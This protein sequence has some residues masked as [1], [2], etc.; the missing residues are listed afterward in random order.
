MASAAQDSMHAN[1]STH[2]QCAVFTLE[3]PTNGPHTSAEHLF[4]PLT[5][6]PSKHALLTN[7]PGLTQDCGGIGTFFSTL[8]FCTFWLLVLSILCV[9]IKNKYPVP[10]DKA[11]SLLLSNFERSFWPTREPG[12]RWLQYV[13]FWMIFLRLSEVVCRHSLCP[14]SD[15]TT[16]LIQF[17]S[18]LLGLIVWGVS[19]NMFNK[20]SSTFGKC[21]HSI[22]LTDINWDNNRTY[23]K[24]CD[25]MLFLAYVFCAINVF[26]VVPPD[27]SVAVQSAY[28]GPIVFLPWLSHQVLQ[29]IWAERLPQIGDPFFSFMCIALFIIAVMWILD[30]KHGPRK[31]MEAIVGALVIWLAHCFFT[32][33]IPLA[34]ARVAVAAAMERN[35]SMD[36]VNHAIKN[37]HKYDLDSFQRLLHESK[38]DRNNTL[39]CR[40]VITVGALLCTD[41]GL[42]VLKDVILMRQVSWGHH[43]WLIFAAMYICRRLYFPTLD[44]DYQRKVAVLEA[45]A[46]VAPHHKVWTDA[47]IDK[48][49]K[50]LEPET[51]PSKKIL[52]GLFV[53]VLLPAVPRYILPTYKSLLS[54]M[55]NNTK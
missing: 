25:E 10:S 18:Q 3:C 17:G 36:R 33:L 24:T 7:P 16:A 21:P 31:A 55:Y 8:H 50:L 13:I 26:L 37:I 28:H 48:L 49:E 46:F 2:G 15:T 11:K 6:V 5:R 30:N 51:T 47:R 52:T 42:Y 32:R 40:V 43:F 35:E 44:L 39:Y 20:V 12:H 9:L 29:A 41:S 45:R 22:V 27:G 53:S 38:L 4:S 54:S 19:L 34:C 1:N 23:R 14:L